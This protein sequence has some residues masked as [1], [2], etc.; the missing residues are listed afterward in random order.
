[1]PGLQARSPFGGARGSHTLTEKKIEKVNEIKRWFF[2]KLNKIDKALPRL[3]RNKK[4]RR[5]IIKLEVI[6]K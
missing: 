6:E 3:I 1:M 5:Q 4:E 2:E